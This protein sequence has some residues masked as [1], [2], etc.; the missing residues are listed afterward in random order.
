MAPNA[1]NRNPGRMARVIHLMVPFRREA[2]LIIT[3][4][5]TLALAGIPLGA[6]L[7]LGALLH[8]LIEVL[9]AAH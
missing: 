3:A 5:V 8:I 9:R 7:A 2:I 4:E 6:H 1:T